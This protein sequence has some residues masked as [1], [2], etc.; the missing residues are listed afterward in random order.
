M[1]LVKGS[2]RKKKSQKWAT[3]NV[4]EKFV[5]HMCTKLESLMKR[6]DYNIIFS[7][8]GLQCRILPASQSLRGDSNFSFAAFPNFGTKARNSSRNILTNETNLPNFVSRSWSHFTSGLLSA[9][10]TFATNRYLPF[11]LFHSWKME[12]CYN[13]SV[14]KHFSTL[15]FKYSYPL[16]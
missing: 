9:R 10:V 13:I 5:C 14:K 15:H 7:K 11:L 8:V 1:Q 6:F 16:P 3:R 2:K 4:N 12:F